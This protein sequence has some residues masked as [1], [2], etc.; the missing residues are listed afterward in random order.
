MRILKLHNPV[1]ICY[2]RILLGMS[3]LVAFYLVCLG[4]AGDEGFHAAVN[5]SA[6][7]YLMGALLVPVYRL[8][9]RYPEALWSSAVW[10]PFGSAIFYGFGPLVEVYGNQ[11]TQDVLAESLLSVDAYALFRANYLSTL[12]IFLL[13]AGFFSH[14][15]LRP[16]LWTLEPHVADSKAPPLIRPFTLALMFVLSGAVLNYAVLKPAQWGMIDIVVP[17]TLTVV[18]AILDVGYG[19]MAYLTTS[20][21]NVLARGVLY[22]TW[23]VHLLLT[24]L[25]LSKLE[26][27]AALLLPALGAYLG[28]KNTKKLAVNFFVMVLVFVLFQPWVH[29]GRNMIYEQTDTISQATY[30]DRFELLGRFLEGDRFTA[31]YEENEQKWWTRLSFVGPQAY[32]MEAYEAG[33]PGST[34]N[35]IWMYF[36]PRVIWQ[37]KPILFGPGATF[38]SLV[39]GREGTSYLALSVYGDLYWNFGWKGILAGCPLIGWLFG[40]LGWRA[41][42]VMYRREFIMIPVVLIALNVAMLGMNRFVITGLIGPLPI[43]FG[44]LLTIYLLQNILRKK[45]ARKDRLSAQGP[46]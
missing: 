24:T 38:Y 11:A 45:S 31:G 46:Y 3:P 2:W 6:P 40:V 34:L 8:A 15:Q 26:I 21:G 29:Y 14:I 43:Y 18:A 25:A 22:T 9:R 28:H 20:R 35:N 19:I 1:A 4:V 30:L 12:G 37:S 39:T 16:G 7:V 33:E 36:V 42:Q 10:L 13:M 17:G 5:G 27:V 44:Y 32:A 23:P 41:I